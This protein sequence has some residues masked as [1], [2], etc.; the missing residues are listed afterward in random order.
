MDQ[1]RLRN[2][3][4]QIKSLWLEVLHVNSMIPRNIAYISFDIFFA[5]RTIDGKILPQLRVSGLLVVFVIMS[6][7]FQLSLTSAIL[8]HL[9]REILIQYCRF[10]LLRFFYRILFRNQ[11]SHKKNMSS[12]YAEIKF[13]SKKSRQTNEKDNE[14]N[15]RICQKENTWQYTQQQDMLIII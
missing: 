9:E 13:K 8:G 3:F 15:I 5:R 10:M 7:F 6:S 4:Q 2:S 14:N 1:N 11:L 12:C